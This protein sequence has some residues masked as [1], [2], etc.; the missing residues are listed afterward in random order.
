MVGRRAVGDERAAARP[1]RHRR[2]AAQPDWWQGPELFV[3]VDD[4]DLVAAAGRN[5]LAGLVDLLP[6]AR[7]IGLHLILARRG[8]RRR[9]GAVRA[10]A[11]AAA[12]AGHAGPA[13]VG[14]PGRGRPLRQLAAQPAAARP[15]ARW[16]AAATAP[17][18]SRPPG[19]IRLEPLCH[20]GRSATVAI[21]GHR[22]IW[23]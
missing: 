23:R 17:I 18:W 6:Q 3:L 2:A 20:A 21:Q 4:Y 10:G 12:G 9:P 1:G 5:P 19:S 8:R 22:N 11:A 7:D 13:D 16:C 14:Q 15:R